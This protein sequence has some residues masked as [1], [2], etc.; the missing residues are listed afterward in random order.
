MIF[1]KDFSI[2]ILTKV[3]KIFLISGMREMVEWLTT[4]KTKMDQLHYNDSKYLL[5]KLLPTLVN[6]FVILIENKQEENLDVKTAILDIFQRIIL[7]DQM[8]ENYREILNL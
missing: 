7:D 3:H 8:I 6:Q 5:K 2:S 1:I 4:L